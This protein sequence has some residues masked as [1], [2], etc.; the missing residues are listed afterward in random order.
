MVIKVRYFLIKVDAIKGC[1]RRSYM[2]TRTTLRV[3]P[4]MTG[5]SEYDTLVVC[6]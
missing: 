6:A 5:P 3:L 1:G 2:L 4:K